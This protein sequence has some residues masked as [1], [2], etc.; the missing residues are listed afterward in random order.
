M[1]PFDHMI[2]RMQLRKLDR[3]GGE[4]GKAAA[5]LLSDNDLFSDFCNE[6]QHQFDSI[7]AAGNWL[8][9]LLANLPAILAAILAIINPP[10]PA[11]T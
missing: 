6:S 11:T 5:L 7:G 4:N 9:W 3:Q 2:V 8:Q 1:G 10:A